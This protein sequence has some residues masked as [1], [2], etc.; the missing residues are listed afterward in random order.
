MIF[1]ENLNFF[2]SSF[3]FFLKLPNQFKKIFQLECDFARLFPEKE[4]LFFTKFHEFYEKIEKATEM[5]KDVNES[6]SQGI[7]LILL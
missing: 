6:D 7:F 1:T 2:F 5:V 3:Y 4:L